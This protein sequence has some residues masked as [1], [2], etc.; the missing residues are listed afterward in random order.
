[1]RFGGGAGAR[2]EYVGVF[3]QKGVVC[4]LPEDYNPTGGV[5]ATERPFPEN[6]V[7]VVGNARVAEDNPITYTYAHFFITFVVLAESGTIIDAE[8][9]FTLSLTNRFVRGLFL[10]RSLASVDDDLL[11]AFRERYLGSSQKALAVAYKDAVKKF[12]EARG[13][14][15]NP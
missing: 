3:R 5:K 2:E 14:K 6:T 4:M 13:D 11:R 15:K 8:G 7:C 9:S 10:G 12:L 1:M